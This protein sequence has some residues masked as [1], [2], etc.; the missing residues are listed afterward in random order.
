MSYFHNPWKRQKTIGLL[1]FS[2]GIEMWHW[3]KMRFLVQIRKNTDEKN[4]EYG[5]FSRSV[6]FNGLMLTAVKGGA[7]KTPQLFHGIYIN[8]IIF[9]IKTTCSMHKF[10]IFGEKR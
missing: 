9:T 4:S 5:H 8:H 2:A 3:T 7:W 1:T 10:P 6:Y